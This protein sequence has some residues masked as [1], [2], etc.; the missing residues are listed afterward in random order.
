MGLF[1]RGGP[2]PWHP[3]NDDLKEEIK[4][5]INKCDQK[6]FAIKKRLDLNNIIFRH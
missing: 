5:C 1:R 2:Q 6:G 4:S 3:A